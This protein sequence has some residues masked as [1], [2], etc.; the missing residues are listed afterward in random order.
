MQGGYVIPIGCEFRRACDENDRAFFIRRADFTR[1]RYAVEPLHLDIEQKKVEAGLCLPLEPQRLRA[2]KALHAHR[3][4]PAL[5]PAA[6]KRAEICKRCRLI[7]A[8]CDVHAVSPPLPVFIQNY[9]ISC[10]RK[11]P[12]E[13]ALGNLPK[14]MRR[15]AL[16]LLTI[17]LPGVL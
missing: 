6:D 5:A 12:A 7:V 14:Y 16:R 1:E 9:S 8:H 13:K 17:P 15:S 4:G 11:Q 2:G 3:V 10:G